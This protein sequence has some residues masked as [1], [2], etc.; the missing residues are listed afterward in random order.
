MLKFEDLPANIQSRI[1]V[2]PSTVSR[3]VPRDTWPQV[4]VSS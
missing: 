2:H 1:N 4:E 3:A